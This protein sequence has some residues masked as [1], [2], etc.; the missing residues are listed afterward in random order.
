M[1]QSVSRLFQL[2]K[3]FQVDI[4]IIKMAANL[5]SPELDRDRDVKR[6]RQQVDAFVSF[7][8]ARTN[9]DGVAQKH[10]V[11][12]CKLEGTML[13][14]EFKLSASEILSVTLCVIS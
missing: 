12:E 11:S 10:R 4:N 5:L 6:W 1:S 8:G 2:H 14:E 7:G 9:Q 3:I 13:N